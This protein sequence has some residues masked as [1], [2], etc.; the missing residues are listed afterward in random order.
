MLGLG[1]NIA[2][3]AV[4]I[5]SEFTP[6]G[7]SL[8]FDGTDDWISF[9]DTDHLDGT[10]D[11]SMQVWL[12]F[13]DATGFAYPVMKIN[14]DS[15]NT[16]GLMTRLTNGDKFQFFLKGGFEDGTGST[17]IASITSASTLTSLEDSWVHV[18][19]TIQR[20]YDGNGR[21]R[22][23]LYINGSQSALSN[24]SSITGSV[25]TDTNGDLVLGGYRSGA[26]VAGEFTG[27]MSEFAIWNT[28]LDADAVSA[29]WNSGNALNAAVD[30]GDYDNSNNLTGYW[31]L[32]ESSGAS[33]EDITSGGQDG[34]INNATWVEDAPWS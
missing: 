27:R 19:L 14:N 3:L 28:L 22:T 16:E 34:T 1:A 25:T 18:V 29:L 12:K 31:R 23:R 7:Y 13:D 15:A 4:V 2:N 5:D 11:I 17:T 6:S 9:G 32:D 33:V 21:S 26:A 24:A 30:D 10:P 8:A 20:D